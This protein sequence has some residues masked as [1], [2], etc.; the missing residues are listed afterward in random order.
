MKIFVL[1]KPEGRSWWALEDF[2]GTMFSM[3]IGRLPPQLTRAEAG[4]SGLQI[5]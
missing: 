3:V 2:S 4:F 5:G 1:I